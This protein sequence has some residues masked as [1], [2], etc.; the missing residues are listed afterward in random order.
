VGR[1][2]THLELAR[3]YE[4]ISPGVGPWRM[5]FWF[6]HRRMVTNPV[7]LDCFVIQLEWLDLYFPAGRLLKGVVAV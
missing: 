4:T 2:G 1:V 7:R 5:K 6:E 3:R